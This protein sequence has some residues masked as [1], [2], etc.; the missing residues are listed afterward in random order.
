MADPTPVAKSGY[1]NGADLLL[2]VGGQAI[3][4]CTT[5]TTTYNSETKERAV[6]PASSVAYAGASLWKEKGIVGLSVSINFEG[7]RHYG[8]TEGGFK[9]LLNAWKTGVPVTVTAYERDS[10]AAPYLSGSFVITSLEEGDPAQDDATYSGTL[11]N[12]GAVTITPAN[13][14]GE[15]IS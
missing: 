1:V 5:H 12:S 2:S 7:L 15:T 9:A 14:T 10:S 13:L 6:K 4:H 8:E 3:G 11:E